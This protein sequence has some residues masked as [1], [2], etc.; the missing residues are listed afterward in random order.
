MKIAITVVLCLFII[1]ALVYFQIK[2][3]RKSK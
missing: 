3:R 2:K 1:G